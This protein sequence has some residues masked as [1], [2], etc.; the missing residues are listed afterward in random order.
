VADILAKHLSGREKLVTDSASAARR[1][2]IGGGGGGAV[3]KI[4]GGAA[5]CDR[6]RALVQTTTVP[7]A[8]TEVCPCKPA[9]DQFSRFCRAH[10]CV[11]MCV[12]YTDHAAAASAATGRISARHA[13]AA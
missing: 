12:Q 1:R 6:R 8:H 9:N 5:R 10:L 4:G 11:D 7:G 2:I 3:K 13:F